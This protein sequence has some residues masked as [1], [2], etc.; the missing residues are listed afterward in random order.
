MV[1]EQFISF[2]LDLAREDADERGK[3]IE[4][5]FT[6][7]QVARVYTRKT[8]PAHDGDGLWFQIK[9]GPI[10]NCLGERERVR[11]SCF[12]G[13]IEGDEAR[14]IAAYVIAKL[15]G[16]QPTDYSAEGQAE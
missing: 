2:T 16:F 9:T 6:A 7:T 13:A 1:S 10:F 3:T 11:K 8:H 14:D 5:L 4:F 15:N 12:S